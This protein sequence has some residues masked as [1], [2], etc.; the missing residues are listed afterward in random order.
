MN[1]SLTPNYN[2]NKY[3]YKTCAGLD[4]SKKPI[5]SLKIKYINKTGLFC[6]RCAVDLINSELAERLG[7]V[8]I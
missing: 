7:D 1:E 6:K 8:N 2:V 3:R 4:C 5:I